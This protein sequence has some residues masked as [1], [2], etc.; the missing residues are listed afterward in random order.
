MSIDNVLAP[1]P[2]VAELT[3]AAS[4]AADAFAKSNPKSEESHLEAL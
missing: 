1:Q 3:R 2:N 4:L